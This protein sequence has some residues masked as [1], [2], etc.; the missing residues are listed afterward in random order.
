MPTRANLRTCVSKTEAKYE[1]SPINVTITS[2]QIRAYA[3]KTY[4][5]V[6]IHLIMGINLLVR[7]AVGYTEA[8][9]L[10]LLCLEE[11]VSFVVYLLN[12]ADEQLLH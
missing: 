2:V 8:G 4:E 3:R 10:Q 5:T 11:E 1:R 7:L 9:R 12:C 6:T